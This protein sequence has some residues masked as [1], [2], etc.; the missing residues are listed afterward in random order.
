MNVKSD[1]LSRQQMEN[2]IKNDFSNETVPSLAEHL[3]SCKGCQKAIL[4]FAGSAEWRSDVEIALQSSDT[5][6]AASLSSEPLNQHQ[7]R[8]MAIAQMTS[9]AAA[10]F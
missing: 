2:L 9:F 5:M 1:C 3:T 8:A 6:S 7:L 10:D 4:E